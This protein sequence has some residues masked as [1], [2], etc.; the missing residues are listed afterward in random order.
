M[1][2]PEMHMPV[3]GD[4]GQTG[5]GHSGRRSPCRARVAIALA[6]CP[7]ALAL[8]TAGTHA[9]VA[10]VAS[11][12]RG[13]PSAAAVGSDELLGV[14]CT[15]REAC[16]AVGTRDATRGLAEGWDQSRASVQ[17]TPLP[18]DENTAKLTGVS[19]TSLTA[20]TAVGYAQSP[21][22]SLAEAWNGATWVVQ[23]TPSAP[24]TTGSAFSGVSC[25]SSAGCV[26]VGL[27]YQGSTVLPLTEVWNGSA[28]NAQTPPYPAGSFDTALNAV[29]CVSATRCVAVGSYVSDAIVAPLAETW[30]GTTWTYQT[31]P[32]PGGNGN[33][34]NG[35]SCVS[36]TTCTAVGWE[37]NG[38]PNLALAEAWNGTKWTVESAP[39]VTGGGTSLSAVS[40]TSA[41][42]CMAVGDSG[43]AHLST[44]AEEWNGTSWQIQAPQNRSGASSNR[45]LSISCPKAATCTAVGSSG[46]GTTDSTL[47]EVWNGTIWTLR[48]TRNPVVTVLATVSPTSAAPILPNSSLSRSHVPRAN[49]LDEGGCE[50]LRSRSCRTSTT[51]RHFARPND[52][53]RPP[54]LHLT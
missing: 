32:G 8:A 23:V 53:C 40:C 4:G 17:A 3:S 38:G 39:S 33:V 11:P 20:C 51:P 10:K 14:S 48:A 25:V 35:V 6:A 42:A 36:V 50:P 21:L 37:V 27:S 24:G 26:A 44:L 7:M 54:S 12:S 19:C 49:Y 28:W 1:H 31:P 9:A 47:A 45:L 41:S 13:L 16:E 2:V 43:G 18:P 29:S 5:T 30:N 22:A 15:A 52:G 34:L 46:T